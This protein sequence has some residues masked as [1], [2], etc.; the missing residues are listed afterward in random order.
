MN[1]KINIFILFLLLTAGYSYGQ[2]NPLFSGTPT[3]DT[4]RV[5]DSTK[6]VQKKIHLRTP[7]VAFMSKFIK[8]NA[9][10]QKAI[11]EKFFSLSNKYKTKKS[12]KGILLIFMFSFLYGILHSLGPGHGKVFV[13]SYILT[14]KPKVLKAIGI[15]YLIAT[16]HAL[17]G[18]LVALIVFFT[19]KTYSA[20]NASISDASNL[21]VRLGFAFLALLGIFMFI[22]NSIGKKHSHN[23]MPEKRQKHLLPFILSIGLVPCPGAIIIVTFLASM[24]LL[25][26]AIA[27]V[28]FIITGMGITISA[29]GLISLFS[30]RLIL[31]LFSKDSKAYKKIYHYISLAGAFLLILFG[32]WFFIGSFY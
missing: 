25:H 6:T 3:T 9:R 7:Q 23:H 1:I 28:F 15:S 16:V 11:K 30:K 4:L 18:L 24:G 12:I 26:I 13:F 31:Q 27:S 8:K 10:L 19:L 20:S 32:T 21:I 29:I 17:S 5:N 22:K 2:E 14:A